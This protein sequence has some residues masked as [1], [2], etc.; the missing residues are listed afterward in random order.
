VLYLV[1]VRI[2]R[3][4]YPPRRLLLIGNCWTARHF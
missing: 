4:R 2:S 3:V 1:E